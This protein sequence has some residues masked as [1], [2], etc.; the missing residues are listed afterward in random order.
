[1]SQSFL[2]GATVLF[3]PS[4]NLLTAVEGES[5]QLTLSNPASQC[6]LLLIQHHGQVVE[7]EHF[8]QQV[9]LNNGSQVTNNN[10]YQ[11][12]S[13]LRRAFKEL[14]L[15]DELIITVPKVGIR[16]SMELAI[17]PHDA[18]SAVPDTPDEC[19]TLVV[20]RPAVP[21]QQQRRIRRVWPVFMGALLAGVLGLFLIWRSEFTP[22]MQRFVLLSEPGECH[23]FGNPD[24]VDYGRHRQF[25]QQHPLDCQYYPWA[26]LTQYPNVQRTS[27]LRCRQQYSA[28][29]DNQCVMSYYIKE[30][31]HAGT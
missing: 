11:N 3:I 16:L 20:P 10:F 22:G 23:I 7:R 26:Y 14:G 2:L 31:T 12:I 15:N 24:V 18:V 25:I 29:R 9:W 13:L 27:V 30:P 28:W 4:R 17:T 21:V 8:F 1:M 19:S 6:L 5:T